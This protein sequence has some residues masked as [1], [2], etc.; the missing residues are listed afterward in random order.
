VLAEEVSLK[1]SNN[2]P[3]IDKPVNSSKIDKHLINKDLFKPP[4]TLAD[5]YLVGGPPINNSL[6]AGYNSAD[7]IWGPKTKDNINK[8]EAFIKELDGI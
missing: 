4:T 8:P 3:L 6:N 5:F 7:N 2:I 1:P